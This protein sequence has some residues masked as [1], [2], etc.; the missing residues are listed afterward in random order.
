MT[1]TELESPKKKPKFK[2]EK[3]YREAH[4]GMVI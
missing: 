3:W 1:E 2:K 4:E